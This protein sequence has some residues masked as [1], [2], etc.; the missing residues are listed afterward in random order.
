MPFACLSAIRKNYG[1]SLPLSTL[2]E[3]PS[4][5]PLAALLDAQSP[6]KQSAAGAQ[7]TKAGAP[8]VISQTEYSSLVP[9]QPIGTSPVFYCAAGMGGNPLNL[10]AL[11]LEMGIDQP[12]YGLQPQG[13]DGISKLHRSIPEMASHYIAE[14]RRK[15]PNGPYYLGG[16]S[17]GGV[18]AFEMAKQLVAAGERIGSLVF[19]DS[20]APGSNCLPCA[21]RLDG[22]IVGLREEGVDYVLNFVKWAVDRRVKKVSAIARKPLAPSVS[23]SLPN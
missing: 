21:R 1:L 11:A 18:V 10:R 14:I 22:H 8:A 5:R 2:F 19:L 7:D 9:I 20:I 13:L 23:L 3:N 17:G 6:Q 4:I 16:Y 12:F 15:Q